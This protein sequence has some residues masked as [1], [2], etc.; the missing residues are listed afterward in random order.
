MLMTLLA[1]LAVEIL[2]IAAMLS[3]ACCF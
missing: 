2:W 1:I 3:G